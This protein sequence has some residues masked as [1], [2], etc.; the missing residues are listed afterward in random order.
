MNKPEGSIVKAPAFKGFEQKTVLYIPADSSARV[1]EKAV[2]ERAE[3]DRELPMGHL[4]G[5]RRAV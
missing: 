3:K 5:L 2:Q 4:Y 1:I